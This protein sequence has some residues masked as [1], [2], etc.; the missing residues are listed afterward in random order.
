MTAEKLFNDLFGAGLVT[1]LIT[2]VASLGMTFSVG[3][4]L[5]PVKRVWLLLATIAVN[6]ALAPLIAIG[7]CHALP[8]SKQAAI[9]VELVTIAAI[10]PAAL[11]ACELA[12]RADMPMA[13]SYTILL[14][15]LNII[16][17][18]LWAKVMVKGATVSVLHILGNLVLIVLLP[19]VVGA[20]LRARHPE[21]APAW[22]SGL[23]KVSNIALYIA[24]AAGLA[25]NWKTVVSTLG[26]WVIVA[27]VVIIL[28]YIAVGWLAGMWHDRQAAITISMLSS[29]RFTPVGLFVI[30]TVLKNQSA[31]LA[32]ALIFCLLDTFIPFGA[33]AEI[34]KYLS[35]SAKAQSHAATTARTPVPP[36]PPVAPV[37]AG[38]RGKVA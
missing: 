37:A 20:V 25:V 16:V 14:G 17:A 2:L 11:K 4:I 33:G 10:G 29:L 18:P 26:S 28:V 34:G 5:A 15:I 9:G 31:Y 6:S 35:R 38:G 36:V 32:P 21:H 27:S 30:A 24:I 8:L 7:I 3:Q 19:L 1:M 22:K 13:V 23:E 12:K